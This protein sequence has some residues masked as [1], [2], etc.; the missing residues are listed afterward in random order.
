M[1]GALA[2]STPMAISAAITIGKPTI[3][4]PTKVK[5]PMA[6]ANMMMIFTNDSISFFR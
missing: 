3:M 5:I 4:P 6:M 1:Q 2:T